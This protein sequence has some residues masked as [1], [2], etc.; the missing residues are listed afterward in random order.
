MAVLSSDSFLCQAC[1]IREDVISERMWLDTH[2]IA[3][4]LQIKIPFDFLISDEPVSWNHG[5]TQQPFFQVECLRS[6]T[7]HAV[8]EIYG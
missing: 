2:S 7:T 1:G 6:D 4:G 8:T 5:D 3:I